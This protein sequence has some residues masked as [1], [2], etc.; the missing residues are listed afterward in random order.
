MHAT[1]FEE[2]RLKLRGTKSVKRMLVSA[3]PPAAKE[4]LLP[5]VARL[6]EHKVEVFA[7]P[8]TARYFGA[9]GVPVTEVR[10]ITEGGEPNIRTLLEGR[11]LDCVINILTGDVDYDESSDSRIIR[12][13]AVTSEIPLFTDVEVS[14][15]QL[16]H[17]LITLS[18]DGAKGGWNLRTRCLE[19]I[20]ERGGFANHHGHFDKA[21]LISPENLVLSQSDMQKKWYLYRFLK[22]NY[23]YEDLYVRI[24]MCV[25]G[26]IS[27]GCRYTRTLVD[28][29]SIVKTLPLEV[30]LDVKAAYKDRI[31]MDIGIQ[32]LE[33]V[34]NP[35]ARQF[36]EKACERAD[37]VGALPSR[38][39]PQPEKHLDIVMKIAKELGKPLDVHVDQENNPD[40]DETELLALKTIEHGLEGRVFGVHCISLA[41][42][43]VETQERIIKVMLDAGLQVI[44]CPSAALSMKALDRSAPLH[45]SIAPVPRLLERGVPVYLGVDNI[46]DLFMPF[47][48]G[49]MWV[50][51]RLL[52]EACRHYDMDAIVDI[53]TRR[54]PWE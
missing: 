26:L 19:R 27:Q 38:D 8:G 13:L 5:L 36:F 51:C 40:E 46:A 10:K 11:M 31:R 30:A 20:R 16:N 14:E 6:T 2:F 3:G 49:D 24:S 50:E 54:L 25:E 9:R 12:S 37:F 21:F 23:T 1:E 34:V 52:M 35:D 53:A 4:R 42:K 39:R 18:D 22:E 47:V 29:D 44:C 33:G 45:N 48:D 17:L 7:T 28:A 43:S 32:P 41:A 15:S